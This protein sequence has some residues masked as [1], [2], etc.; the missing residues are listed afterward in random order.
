MSPSFCSTS[1]EE[2]LTP[3]VCIVLI[4]GIPAS[5]KTYIAKELVAKEMQ[6]FGEKYCV[7]HVC[8]DDFYPKDTRAEDTF[9]YGTGT[10][11]R[12]GNVLVTFKCIVVCSL[13][14]Y[15]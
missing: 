14:N 12:K 8:M 5:G 4:F 10:L 13:Q 6:F 2:C 1:D 9:G 3:Q 7:V 15:M 11:M